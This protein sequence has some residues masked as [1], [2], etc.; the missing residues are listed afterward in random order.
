L[1]RNQMN[2]GKIGFAALAVACGTAL[3]PVASRAENAPDTPLVVPV[4]IGDGPGMLIPLV[5]QSAGLDAEQSSDAAALVEAEGSAIRERLKQIARLDV[6]LTRRIF[7]G[8]RPPTQADL[9]PILK[10]MA[11]LRQEIADREVAILVRVRGG[12]KPE[13]RAA[14]TA[15]HG[16]L[17]KIVSQPGSVGSSGDTP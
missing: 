14:V 11:A 15:M 3:L 4:V 12:L 7:A 5:L 6:E 8:G 13:Q 9:A 16:Q 2:F 17:L 1:L 10:R